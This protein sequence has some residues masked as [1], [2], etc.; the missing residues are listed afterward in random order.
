MAYLFIVDG[1]NKKTNKQK[2]VFKNVSTNFY[3]PIDRQ[4]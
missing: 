1:D 4:L 2:E 3:T